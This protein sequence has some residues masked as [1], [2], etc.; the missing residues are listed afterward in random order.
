MEGTTMKFR[1][2]SAI[3][4]ATGMLLTGVVLAL[5]A[6]AEPVSGSYAAVGSDTL[7]ASMN[8][9]ANGTTVTGSTVRV[10]AGGNN[11][12]NYDAFPTG[13][14][15]QTK[16]NGPNY[17]RP[18]GSGNGR[19]A[20]RAS[21]TGN[22]WQGTVITG[23]VDIA[24]SSSG[25]G[26]NANAAGLLAYVPY[27]R[28]AVAY[29]Y[30]A[31]DSAAAAV[32]ADLSTAELTSIYSASSPTVIDGIT[33]NPRL[34]QSGSGTRSFFLGAIAVPT[35]GTAVPAGDNTATGPAENDATVLGVNQIIPFSVANWVAQS[36]G[37][38]PSTI[39]ATGVQIG[40]PTGV[41]PF[42]GTTTLVP[43]AAYYSN[44]TWG[45]DTYLIAEFARINSA[46][47]TYDA[48]LAA[49]VTSLTSYG[50]LPSSPGAVKTRFG[51]RAP[52][53]TTVIRAYTVL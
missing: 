11:F 15:I 35:P 43:A 36:N 51:F 46:S 34:P 24:R 39:G 5:P 19:D 52:S 6:S 47:G 42:T 22:A 37:A 40:S 27:A 44:T 9:L 28:D 49:L 18:S 50:S 12:G 20:L 7:E 45:R 4:A 2:I 17:V 30:K 25:P 1:K 33:I 29:A 38:A 48:N 31:A 41:A 14:R 53:S 3:G 13:T 16:P 21:I 8:A 32:L 23:Q 26:S 10:G